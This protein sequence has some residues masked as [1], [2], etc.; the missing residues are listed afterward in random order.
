MS[1]Y[2]AKGIEASAQSKHYKKNANGVSKHDK[3]WQSTMPNGFPAFPQSCTFLL[4]FFI[5]T[6]QNLTTTGFPNDQ[7]PTLFHPASPKIKAAKPVD[8]GASMMSTST[9][10]STVSLLKEKV[11]AKFSSKDKK[12]ERTSS[13][14]SNEPS[15]RAQTAEAYKIIAMTK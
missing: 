6:F 2:F 4:S 3:A 11:H 12:Q 9:F 14:K 1:L 15:A 8:D 7:P 10:A 13:P 5:A